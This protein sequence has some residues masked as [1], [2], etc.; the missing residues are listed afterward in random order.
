MSLSGRWSSVA[1]GSY[2]LIRCRTR[3]CTGGG[4]RAYETRPRDGSQRSDWSVAS[5]RLYTD[6]TTLHRR[7]SENGIKCVKSPAIVWPTKFFVR[8]MA[9]KWPMIT[10]T[11]TPRWS[12]PSK[13][14]DGRKKSDGRRPSPVRVLPAQRDSADFLSESVWWPVVCIH[15]CLACLELFF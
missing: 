11:W 10:R 6:E 2:R 15:V 4:A 3:T 12:P 14:D 9:E 8:P 5:G 13:F 1:D 7:W